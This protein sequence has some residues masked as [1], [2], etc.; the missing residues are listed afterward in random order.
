VSSTT[1]YR[2]LLSSFF[3]SFRDKNIR[4]RPSRMEDAIRSFDNK[5]LMIRRSKQRRQQTV[6]HLIWSLYKNLSCRA[7][8]IIKPTTYFVFTTRPFASNFFVACGSFC[9]WKSDRTVSL[10]FNWLYNVKLLFVDIGCP[11]V[12]QSLRYLIL[13]RIKNNVLYVRCNS[14]VKLSQVYIKFC[15]SKRQNINNCTH[16]FGS[17]RFSG[18]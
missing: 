15:D 18:F 11:P 3:L 5:N 16:V 2:R 9:L 1:H 6:R 8:R 10:L 7:L 13:W 12:R 4:Q 17:T 14:W